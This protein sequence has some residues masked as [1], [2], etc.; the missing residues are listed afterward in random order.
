MTCPNTGDLLCPDTP[1]GFTQ[2]Q[3]LLTF[4]PSLDFSEILASNRAL[5]LSW[6]QPRLEP[7]AVG[8]ADRV[9][10]LV[11]D[12]DWPEP[13][14]VTSWLGLDRSLCCGRSKLRGGLLVACRQVFLTPGQERTEGIGLLRP[15]HVAISL[16]GD[17]KGGRAK[18]Q[19]KAHTEMAERKEGA[20]CS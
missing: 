3:C 7:R 8:N 18:W 14:A 1:H 6:V 13:H 12:F 10:A 16:C 17:N 11:A 20:V 5:I 15:L 2:P 19:A 9:L 4:L